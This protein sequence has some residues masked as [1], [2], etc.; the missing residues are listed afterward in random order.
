MP[1]S[2]SSARKRKRR[3]NL[4][5]D[6]LRR[7]AIPFTLLAV[8][9]IA[10]QLTK[11]WVLANLEPGE[12]YPVF[13]SFFQLRLI[14]NI[15]GAMGTALGSGTFYLI[16]SLIILI[17]VFYLIITNK[18]N[19]WTK[20]SLTLIAAGAIGNI[21]DRLRIGMVVDFLDVDIPDID[22]LGFRL[23]RWW[24]FNIADS[25]ISIGMIILMLFIIFRPQKKPET[26]PPSSISVSDS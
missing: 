4:V 2:V 20:Y 24:T 7:L 11:L 9:V 12:I 16:S 8:I 25:A 15:G 13:G 21:I 14:Y 1:D 22:F 23:E 19:L 10:D 17:A 5:G 26:A 3:L 18:D 6:Y